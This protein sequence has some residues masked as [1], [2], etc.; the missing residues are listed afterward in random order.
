MVDDL[1]CEQVEIDG[2][3]ADGTILNVPTGLNPDADDRADMVC[4]FFATVHYDGA[5]GDDL[6]YET[7]GILDMNGGNLA[8]CTVAP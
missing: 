6:G 1:F 5:T 8:A 4:E 7:V 2:M 3:T